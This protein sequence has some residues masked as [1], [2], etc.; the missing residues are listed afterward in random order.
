VT[1]TAQPHGGLWVGADCHGDLDV[2]EL[3]GHQQQPLRH[4]EQMVVGG[5]VDETLVEDGGA[6]QVVQQLGDLLHG[7]PDELGVVEGQ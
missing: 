4:D 5:S 7:L 2:I 6:V 1:A 3:A